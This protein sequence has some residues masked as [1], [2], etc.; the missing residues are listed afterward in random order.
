M[1]RIVKEFVLVADRG[2]AKVPVLLDSGASA[3]ILRSDVAARIGTPRKLLRPAVFGSARRKV[4]MTA[5]AVVTVQVVV[6]DKIL[7][8]AF[9]VSDELSREAIIG[10]DFMQKWDVRLQPRAHRFT[11]GIDPQHLEVF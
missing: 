10:A 6:N 11:V 8:C 5:D 2:R 7:D 4:R 3:S 1:G 9:Y